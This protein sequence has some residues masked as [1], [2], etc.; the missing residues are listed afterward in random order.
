M[1]HCTARQGAP[2]MRQ[3]RR[4]ERNGSLRVLYAARIG[5]C[6]SCPLRKQCQESA[7]TI[8]AR[9]GSRVYWPVSSRSSISGK[10]PPA[11]GEPS[12]PPAPHPVL[13][14]D[15]QRRFHRRELVKLLANQ[16]VDVRLVETSPPTPSCPARHLS[17]AE[18]A[19]WR[20]SWAERL[21]RNARTAPCVN[22]TLFGVPQ[23]FAVF[24]VC[25]W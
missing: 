8:K 1:G 7:T 5:H 16:R 18:R 19:H 3:P 24:G 17:R 12:P 14:G 15:W 9:R 13:W 2:C 23:P 20:L 11:P 4:S 10:S 22:I 25:P 21:A 6:R